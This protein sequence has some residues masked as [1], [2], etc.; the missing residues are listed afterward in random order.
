MFDVIFDFREKARIAACGHRKDPPNEPCY[1]GVVAIDSVRLA[2][3][4]AV[5]DSMQ[6]CLAYCGNASLPGKI[7]EHY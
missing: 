3:F 1:P 5:V 7:H 4:L 6:S 2:L